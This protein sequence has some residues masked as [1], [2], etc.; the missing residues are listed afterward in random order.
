MRSWTMGT[1]GDVR[2]QKWGAVQSWGKAKACR[3]VGMERVCKG[4]HAC[5]SVEV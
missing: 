1:Q 2:L 5:V 3:A 4:V